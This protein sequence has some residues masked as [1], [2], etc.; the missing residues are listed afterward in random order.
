[1]SSPVGRTFRS[2]IGIAPGVNLGTLS[3][4]ER[5]YQDFN[6]E[7]ERQA[8][9]T[10]N[11]VRGA[12]VHPARQTHLQTD[13]KSPKSL[14]SQQL[15]RERRRSRHPLCFRAAAPIWDDNRGNS[16]GDAPASPHF[17]VYNQPDMVRMLHPPSAIGS[18]PSGN[19]VH[20]RASWPRATIEVLGEAPPEQNFRQFRGALV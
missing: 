17:P 12:C 3:G 18:R 1:M 20:L 13:R 9:R 2:A 15:M 4:A 7:P 6:P 5:K 10:Q 16:R 8:R 14:L 11:D 19:P